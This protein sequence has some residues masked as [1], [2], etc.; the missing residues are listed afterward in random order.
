[1][2]RVFEHKVDEVGCR[3]DELV[4]LLEVLQLTTLL[5][6]EDVEVVFGCVQLHVLDLCCQVSLL[7]GDLFVALLELLFLLLKG[8][9]FLV[10]LLLH[11]LVQILLLD[12]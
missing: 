1:M 11:H 4:Q 6:I 8:A 10:N 9:D 3:L 5:F 12:F 2:N 7:L